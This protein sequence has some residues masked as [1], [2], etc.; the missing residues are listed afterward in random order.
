[1]NNYVSVKIPGYSSNEAPRIFRILPREEIE[2][3]I[4]N[5][6]DAIIWRI[7]YQTATNMKHDGTAYTYVDARDGSICTGWLGENNFQHPWDSFSE[8]WLCALK[9]GSD[10]ID[11]D[12]PDELLDEDEQID[13]VGY[14]GSIRK[15]LE[16]RGEDYEERFENAIDWH[17]SE[18]R[19][20][21]DAIAK[22]LDKLYSY[23]VDAE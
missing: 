20:D 12:T 2:K 4:D 18:F 14:D 22:D 7:T 21:M 19:I 6:D 1:M 13:Y 17:A 9:S 16:E 15:F 5:I 10:M 8:I 11:L 3:I 23:A